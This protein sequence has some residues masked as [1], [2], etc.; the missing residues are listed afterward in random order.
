MLL[1][2]HTRYL[3]FLLPFLA[4]A[5]TAQASDDPAAAG[6]PSRSFVGDDAGTTAWKDWHDVR[7]ERVHG[8]RALGKAWTG[9]S[10]LA[11]AGVSGVAAM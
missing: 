2:H 6:S 7:F 9:S 10:T 11:R 4:A 3:S 1:V 8:K 5:A